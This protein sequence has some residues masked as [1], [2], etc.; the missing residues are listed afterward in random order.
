MS[1][2][3][4]DHTKDKVQEQTKKFEGAVNK[5]AEAKEKEVMDN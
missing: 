5:G 1:E 3:A 2:D 4:R